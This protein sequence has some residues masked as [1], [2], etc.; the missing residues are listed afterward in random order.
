MILASDGPDTIRHLSKFFDVCV[1]GAGPAGLAIAAALG[2]AGRHVALI[3][4]GGWYSSPG[5]QEL[6]D[7]D[8]DAGPYA[9]LSCTRHRQVGGTVNIWDV[10]VGGRQGAKFVPLSQSDLADWPIGW[11]EL[12]PHYVEAQ[13]LCGLGPFEYGA[14]YWATPGHRPFELA[15]TGLQNAVYQFGFALGFTHGLVDSLRVAQAVTLAPSITVVK[16]LLDKRSHKVSGVRG[17][18]SEGKVV[19]VRA[20]IFILACGAVENARLLLLAGLGGK[21]GW[22]GQGFMEHARD[23]SMN[24][25]PF[26]RALFAEASFYDLHTSRDGFLV[27]GRLTLSEDVIRSAG[28]PNGSITLV[29]KGA[30]RLFERLYHAVDG[31]FGSTRQRRYGWSKVRSPAKRFDSFGI[32]LNLEQRPHRWNRIELSNRQD[33]FGNPLPRLVLRWTD[34]E[35]NKLDELRG[36][37]REWFSTASLGSLV[38][39][40]GRHP[41]LSAH[42]HAGTTRMGT[43]PEEGVV[44]RDGRMFELDNL[45][46][47]GASVFPTAGFANPTLTI[48]AMALRLARHINDALR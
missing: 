23:F 29:P 14:T 46:L 34:R 43:G 8:C 6:N 10:G 4:S 37:L 32:K 48:V 11:K 20:R 45:Y 27:G 9:G 25:V 35:Q 3:E 41:S 28:L 15:G 30:A 5:D 40:K 16:L 36:L 2:S 7:G 31:V 44:D 47:A 42:H 26:S 12:E 33:R 19:E 21:S 1:V 22:L 38:F 13:R 39:T 24:L 18:T 17:V